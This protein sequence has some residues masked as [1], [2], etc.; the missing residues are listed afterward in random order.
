M[1]TGGDATAMC[2]LRQSDGQ[3][4]VQ[5]TDSLSE[6]CDRGVDSN[7]NSFKTPDKDYQY[8]IA[9]HSSMN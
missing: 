3:K 9:K 1:D 6:G 5:C 7:T 2:Q 8:A 4:T